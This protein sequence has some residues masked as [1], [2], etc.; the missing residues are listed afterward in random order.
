VKLY[1]FP[2]GRAFGVIALKNYLELDCEI[3]HLDIVPDADG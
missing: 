2:A 3:V 1:L